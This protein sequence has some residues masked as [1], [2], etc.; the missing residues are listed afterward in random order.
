MTGVV[1]QVGGNHYEAK[2]QHWDLVVDNDIQY[3]EGN[4]TKYISRWRKK[5]GVQDIEK[6]ISYVQKIRTSYLGNHYR[7]RSAFAC[8]LP[9]TKVANSRTSFSR[10]VM[11]AGVLEE[12]AALCLRVLTWK[13]LESLDGVI[14]ALG[15]L[16]LRGLP[17]PQPTTA[18]PPSG[19][20]TVAQAAEPGHAGVQGAGTSYGNPKSVDMDQGFGSVNITKTED[21]YNG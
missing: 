5:N 10:W 7:N 3:L 15:G 2:Y 16:V 20:P 12:D 13:D 8:H 11:N 14:E 4:A 9:Y 6:A 18:E 19:Q 17:T 1:K 21:G